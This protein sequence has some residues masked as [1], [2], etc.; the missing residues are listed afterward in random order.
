[1]LGTTPIHIRGSSV[2]WIIPGTVNASRELTGFG[3]EIQ[4]NVLI[5]TEVKMHAWAEAAA[6]N[7]KEWLTVLLDHGATLEAEKRQHGIDIVT[8]AL[9]STLDSKSSSGGSNSNYAEISFTSLS[10]G[11][12][13]MN[14]IIN[15]IKDLP[16]M[17][18]V[19]SGDAI[20]AAEQ[21]FFYMIGTLEPFSRKTQGE[22]EVTIQYKF[23]GNKFSV[24]STGTPPTPTYPSAPG[25]TSITPIGGAG[26]GNSTGAYP[27]GTGLPLTPSAPTAAMITAMCN[28]E[29]TFQP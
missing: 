8:G 3:S 4:H 6:T 10:T 25:V 27:Y 26:T 12:T 11:A 15:T 20:T 16:C 21:G 1:M 23:K 14:E 7:N 18:I 13:A 28:G 29:L 22:K 5:D 17:V 19:H 2:A 24:P 9:K